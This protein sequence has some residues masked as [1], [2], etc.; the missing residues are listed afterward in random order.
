[1]VLDRVEETAVKVVVEL[2]TYPMVV[3]IQEFLEVQVVLEFL[4]VYLD[5]L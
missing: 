4:I 5:L 3:I 1:V 2:H